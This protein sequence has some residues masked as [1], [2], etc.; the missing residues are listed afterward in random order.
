MFSVFAADVHIYS[1]FQRWYAPL[2]GQTGFEAQGGCGVDRKEFLRLYFY[3]CGLY[4]SALNRPNA[5]IRGE[6]LKFHGHL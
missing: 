3:V 5:T 2:V 4:E 1:K 6:Y